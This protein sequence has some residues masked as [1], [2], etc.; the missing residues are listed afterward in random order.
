M[1][2]RTARVVGVACLV[3]CAATGCSSGDG[4]E[5]A[6]GST[7]TL[8]SCDDVRKAVATDIDATLTASNDELA[9]QVQDVAYD[10]QERPGAA[11]LFDLYSDLGYE[12]VYV[13]ARHETLTF[14]GSDA[15]AREVTLDWLDL[16]GF[17][18]GEGEAVLYLAPDNASVADPAPYKAGVVDDLTAQGYEFDFGYGD[19]DTDF[20]AFLDAGVAEVFS[21]GELA[22]YEGTTGIDEA[23]YGDHIAERV[24]PLD[25]VCTRDGG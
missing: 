17:P 3:L 13:T 11:R 12:I 15:S 9:M 10:Q 20:E 19:A 14:T 25:A 23:G 22:G 18:T 6:D 7:T 21:V 2:S 1:P 8:A 5:A 4:E 24:E 16:H